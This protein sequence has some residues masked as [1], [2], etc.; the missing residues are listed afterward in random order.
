MNNNKSPATSSTARSIGL[1]L[2]LAFISNKVYRQLTR[3]SLRNKVVLITGGAR[4]LGLALARE[5]ASKGA[6]LILCSRTASQLEQARQELEARGCPVFTMVTDVRDEKQVA[7]LFQQS[8]LR[9]GRIDML[10]NNAGI[11]MVGPQNVMN[12]DDFKN[13]METN[14]WSALHSIKA[15]LPIFKSQRRGH[16][17]NICSIGGKFAVPHMLPY[18]VSKFAM[19]GLSQGL[20]AE[21]AKDRVKVTTVIPNL[22]RTGSP[23]NITVKGNHEAE[24]GWFKLAGSFPLVSQNAD[25]AARQIVK[26]IEAGRSEIVLTFTAK[27]VSAVQGIFPGALRTVAKLMNAFLPRSENTAVKKG[28]EAETRLTHG[29]IGAISDKAADKYNQY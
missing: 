26:G 20:A 13:A 29:V 22:M 10:I 11:M 16:I 27:F 17:V 25:Q 2:A 21:L 6:S 12:I 8:I 9:F 24:Y 1:V 19:V 15:A 4:G 18:S 23:R 14:V 7:D 3:I 28:W 5:L